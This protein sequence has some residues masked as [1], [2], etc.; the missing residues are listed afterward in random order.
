MSVATDT[1]EC[2]AEEHPAPPGAL[3]HPCLHLRGFVTYV[4]PHVRSDGTPVKGHYRRQRPRTATVRTAPRRTAPRRAPVPRPRPV[5]TGPT[6]HVV[7]YYRGDGARVRGHR[8][9]VS[10]RT[11][12]V[13]AGTGGGFILLILVLLALASGPGDTSK[14]PVRTTPSQSASAPASHR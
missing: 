11:V 7:P 6:T 2:C 4:R 3:I 9:S 5:P 8:R 14:T 1:V 13:A 10:P 12:A